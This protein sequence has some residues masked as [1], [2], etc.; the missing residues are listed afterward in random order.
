MI[1]RLNDY[2]WREVFALAGEQDTPHREEK[3]Y[4]YC[5]SASISAAPPG[6]DLQR[7]PFAREDVTEIVWIEDGENDGPDWLIGGTLQDGRWFFIAAGC[8]YTG[9]DCQSGGA[10]YVASNRD[11]IER[12]AMGDEERRRLNVVLPE[13]AER[14]TE[15]ARW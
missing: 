7:G 3:N 5:N 14:R 4:G 9:W 11:D 6:A 2:D 10:A 13:G 1:E 12:F 15:K 8:D